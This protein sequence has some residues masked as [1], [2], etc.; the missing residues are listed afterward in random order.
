MSVCNVPTLLHFDD[1]YSITGPMYSVAICNMTA[2]LHSV[3]V[4]NMT[5]LLHSI[6]VSKMTACY[7]LL[8]SVT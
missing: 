6:G 8:M 1:V 7:T 5:A 2:L 4:C 3:D